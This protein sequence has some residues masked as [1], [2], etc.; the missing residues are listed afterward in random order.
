MFKWL[1]VGRQFAQELLNT[2]F[3]TIK[4]DFCDIFTV[5]FSIYYTLITQSSRPW[6]KYIGYQCNRSRRN[7]GHGIICIL[8][9]PYVKCTRQHTFYQSTFKAVDQLI[10]D[11]SICWW[12]NVLWWRIGVGSND[13]RW[14]GAW[15]L[16]YIVTAALCFLIAIPLVGYPRDLPGNT[17]PASITIWLRVLYL[18]FWSCYAP[19]L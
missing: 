9:Q 15:W 11:W 19:P 1:L 6:S 13:Q 12:W 7:V 17:S 2:W 16:P 4:H 5:P 8:Y 18:D 3:R 10:C 14:V